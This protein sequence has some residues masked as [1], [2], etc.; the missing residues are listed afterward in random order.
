MSNSTQP[1]P[2][3]E[4][5]S[6]PEWDAADAAMVVFV[7]GASAAVNATAAASQQRKDAQAALVA[8]SN[9]WIELK[10]L[11]VK[12]V[13]LSIASTTVIADL[14][15]ASVELKAS[16]ARI[17]QATQAIQDVTKFI[18]DLTKVATQVGSLVGLLGAL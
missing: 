3:V 13:D 12:L 8:F 17:A 4:I 16:A 15:K 18:A 2:L 1:T 6:L 10:A 14:K 9:H 11:G 5:Q 7:Q